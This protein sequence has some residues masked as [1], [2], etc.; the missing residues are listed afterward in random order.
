M[1][2]LSNH[3]EY[4][5]GVHLPG[6]T[7]HISQPGGIKALIAENRLLEATGVPRHPFAKTRPQSLT[8]RS[9]PLWPLGHLFWFS[10]LVA[11]FNIPPMIPQPVE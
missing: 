10:T 4:V 11:F 2:V 3:E 6:V 5:H 8:S 7:T 1:L 9:C